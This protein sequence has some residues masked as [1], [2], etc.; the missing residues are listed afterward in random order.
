M[1]GVLIMSYAYCPICMGENKLATEDKR[2][3][4]EGSICKQCGNR[5]PEREEFDKMVVEELNKLNK[6]DTTEVINLLAL[7]V[8]T[9]GLKELASNLYF[10]YPDLDEWETG[11]Y[12]FKHPALMRENMLVIEHLKNSLHTRH[13]IQLNSIVKEAMDLYNAYLIFNY[14]NMDMVVE[15]IRDLVEACEMEL[16]NMRR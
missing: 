11:N 7:A 3:F 2:V 14:P 15:K 13:E 12:G 9:L 4:K 1:K 6:N 8:E 10:N 16:N 5:V